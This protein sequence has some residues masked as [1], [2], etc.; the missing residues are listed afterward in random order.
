MNAAL[1]TLIEHLSPA[2]ASDEGPLLV[3]FSGGIDST[4]LLLAAAALRPD[5]R[6]LHINHGLHPEARAWQARCAEVAAGLGVAFT[7]VTVTV[8]PAGEGLEAAARRARYAAFE[9]ALEA[10]GTLLLGH[11]QGDQA[12]TVLMRLARGAGVRGLS[13]MDAVRPLGR[14]WIVRPWLALP[15]RALEGAVLAAGVPWIEDPSN[16]DVAHRRNFWR[17]EV[18][19]LIAQREGDFARRVAVAAQHL[20]AADRLLGEYAR[21][22][23]VQ[24]QP[25]SEPLGHS[26][27]CTAFAGW[28]L[29]RRA[30]VLRTWMADT[31]ALYMRAEHTEDLLQAIERKVGPSYALCEGAWQFRRFRSRLYA[32]PV[33]LPP[34][35]LD[36]EP[37]L[38][39]PRAGARL[40]LPDGS[41]LRA[42]AADEGLR[43]DR[44]YCVGARPPGLRARPHGRAHSQT[45]KKLLQE[46]QLP[47][48][49][50]ERV[51]L[52]WCGDA[53]A[54]VA[55]Q[56]VEA[57]FWAAA[58]G[59]C[60]RLTWGWPG[61]GEH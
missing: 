59:P 47:P 60:L 20:G 28:S 29:E 4:A 51:P 26:I 11:H 52:L 13:G 39:Q 45:L 23:R 44:V 34:I 56:W 36:C 48:W 32:L 14:G 27:D 43:A 17:R 15:K 7:A 5:V 55:G 33:R 42:H 50:R 16:D 41:E 21:L 46:T 10:G 18:L 30:Q 57:D 2:L 58:P 49:L 40:I 19:P 9:R 25:R 22:D 31:C 35:G 3:A 24:L 6:A 38:W 61:G 8:T 1:N 12:E 53:L 37:L 54:A